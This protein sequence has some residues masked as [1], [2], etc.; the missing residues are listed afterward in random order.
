MRVVAC[1]Y[2]K[3]FTVSYECGETL[4][5]CENHLPWDIPAVSWREGICTSVH[6]SEYHETSVHSSRADALY[7]FNQKKRC[8]VCDEVCGI[9][10]LDCGCPIAFA[11]RPFYNPVCEEE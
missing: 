3:C 11:L 8:V 5:Y 2:I 6:K 7:K 10:V 1:S 9:V 4:Q